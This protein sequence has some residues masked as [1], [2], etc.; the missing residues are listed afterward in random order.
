MHQYLATLLPALKQELGRLRKVLG[1]LVVGLVV[2]RDSEERDIATKH[3]GIPTAVECGQCAHLVATERPAPVHHSSDLDTVS[4]RGWAS[5]VA[6]TPATSARLGT[7]D[8]TFLI[9]LL[10]GTIQKAI[11]TT[12]LQAIE[13]QR[14]VHGPEPEL[15]TIF[16]L[17]DEVRRERRVTLSEILCKVVSCWPGIAKLITYETVV[18]DDGGKLRSAQA[19]V[20]IVT[21]PRAV[22]REKHHAM[23]LRAK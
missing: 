22:T 7:K 10:Q 23:D 8:R 6:S 16:L 15:E 3:D 13:A 14:V 18:P 11:D 5:R 19:K 12:L 9:A 1:H 20:G 21:T 17:E 2:G 4:L